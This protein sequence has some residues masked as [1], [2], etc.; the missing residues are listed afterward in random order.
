MKNPVARSFGFVLLAGFLG[1][2]GQIFGQEAPEIPTK[3]PRI[4]GLPM[5]AV[6][7]LPGVA[8]LFDLRNASESP[9]IINDEPY[10][11]GEIVAR[12]RLELSDADVLQLALQAGASKAVRK[13]PLGLFV[14]HGP[15]NERAMEQTLQHLWESGKTVMMSPNYTRG[16][17]TFVP[18]DPH[19]TSGAQWYLD[20]PSDIDLDLPDAWDITRGSAS[21]VVAVMD[22]GILSAH[23]EFVGR[24]WV[25]PGEIPGNSVDDDG[26]GYIDDIN[27]WNNTANN[28]DIEDDDGG[29]LGNGVGHGT[30]VSS[31]LL[32]NSNNAH[33][34]AGFD[35]FARQLTVR[36]FNQA[37]GFDLGH[38][39]GGL[40][41]LLMTSQYY[42]VVNMSWEASL[43][44]TPIGTSLDALEQAG[45][46][47]VAG[48][49]NDFGSA[50]KVYPAAH[51]ATI[52]VGATDDTDTLAPFSNTGD[53]V[54]FVAPGVDIYTA[55]FG[56]PFSA[57]AS[58]VGPG[59]SFS[60]P[61]VTG[62]ASL[63][64][65]IRSTM[66]KEELVFALKA[67]AVDLGAPGKD[68]EHGW[69]RVNAHQALQ[70]HA[71]LIFFGDF[72]TGDLS[73][74]TSS[75]P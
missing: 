16:G 67:S 5:S 47:V 39:L 68:P 58:Q 19:S 53:E 73:R 24:L 40:D 72:E 48:S 20:A 26:N 49:G 4:V 55:S 23:P 63:G 64:F 11:P 57:N 30:W 13:S 41:Y 35:H 7:H 17:L 9:R 70:V 31:I 61:M 62:I 28:P 36:A 43:V 56:D 59:T 69:G 46:L 15:Q 54:D 66:T 2:A 74:W 14:L 1:S 18:N 32:A 33:Q 65:A 45:A 44:N 25:N 75:T 50:K 3:P 29:P 6:Q 27:G 12:F 37:T 10:L 52:T 22:T 34:V 42:D 51:S 60:T 38:V 8:P 71:G 21:V